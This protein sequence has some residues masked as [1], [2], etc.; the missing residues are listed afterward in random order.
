MRKWR[1]AAVAAAALALSGCGGEDSPTSLSDTKVFTVETSN[2]PVECIYV[3][4]FQQG[5]LS[6]D[7]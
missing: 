4:G 2:G 5:G 3:N 1:I 7:W 6:C